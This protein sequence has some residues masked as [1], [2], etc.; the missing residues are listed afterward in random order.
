MLYCLFSLKEY[1]NV[2]IIERFALR[3]SGR[4]IIADD[5]GLGKTI[6]AL[7]VASYYYTEW[8]LLVICPAS[9]VIAWFEAVLMWLPGTIAENE[10][11]IVRSKKDFTANGRVFVVSYDMSVRLADYLNTKNFNVVI[12]DESHCL[13]NPDSKRSKLIVPLLQKSSRAILLSGTPALSSPIELYQQIKALHPKLFP[14]LSSYGKRY[15]GGVKGYFGW[16]YKKATNSKEL[17]FIL[18]SKLLIRR[19][20]DEVLNELPPKRRNQVLGC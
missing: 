16:E 3:N 4:V 2:Y 10:I 14:S 12:A 18:K 8:P 17:L 20:K 5:M 9:L 19:L 7:G 11:V 13:K 6:Q 15:C 1:S